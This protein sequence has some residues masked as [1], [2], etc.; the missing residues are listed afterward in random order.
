MKVGQDVSDDQLQQRIDA[1]CPNKCCTLIYTVSCI[2]F[3]FVSVNKSVHLICDIYLLVFLVVCSTKSSFCD[4]VCFLAAIS[5]L[6]NW[7]QSIIMNSYHPIVYLSQAYFRW[8]SPH[9]QGLF[10]VEQ[11]YWSWLLH[12]KQLVVS[13]SLIF[14]FL[15]QRSCNHHK[16]CTF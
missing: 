4:E 2:C 16:L 12:S 1:Q 5:F 14:T 15:N 3:L 13:L 11:T 9:F 10:S 6:I 8:L 7:L